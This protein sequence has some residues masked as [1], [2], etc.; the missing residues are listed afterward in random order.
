MSGAV[1]VKGRYSRHSRNVAFLSCPNQDAMSA[2]SMCCLISR[3]VRGRVTN[4]WGTLHMA[5]R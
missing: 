4:T 1:L 3:G 5:E 2:R